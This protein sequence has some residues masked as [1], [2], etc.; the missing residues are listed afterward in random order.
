ML[1]WYY[2]CTSI[3]YIPIHICIITAWHA[4]QKLLNYLSWSLI[5]QQ[6]PYL[7]SLLVQFVYL[8]MHRPVS[9]NYQVAEL[10]LKNRSINSTNRNFCIEILLYLRTFNIL[11]LNWTIKYQEGIQILLKAFIIYFIL[12]IEKI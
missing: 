5:L 11:F 4:W 3:L 2:V 8:S 6:T 1:N 12:E 7:W 10:C 9:Y